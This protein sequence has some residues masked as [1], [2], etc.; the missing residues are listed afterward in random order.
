MLIDIIG[1]IILSILPILITI[2]QA[3]IMGVRIENNTWVYLVVFFVIS[4][5]I[6]TPKI[7][8][9][10]SALMLIMGFMLGIINK[11]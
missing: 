9:N 8:M 10:L 5:G 3:K 6:I 7:D 11:D 2:T 4:L 1:N